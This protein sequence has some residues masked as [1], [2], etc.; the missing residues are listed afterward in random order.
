MCVMD[1][2]RVTVPKNKDILMCVM[3]FSRVSMPKKKDILC[4]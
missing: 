3:D 4:V 2:S 1:F